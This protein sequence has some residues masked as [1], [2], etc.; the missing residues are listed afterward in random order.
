MSESI[1]IHPGPVY[2]CHNCQ[3][4][5]HVPRLTEKWETSIRTF[6]NGG[7]MENRRM[8]DRGYTCSKCNIWNS[9]KTL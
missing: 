6:D 7:T 1:I 9:L 3:A 5:L 4:L 8:T 2:I